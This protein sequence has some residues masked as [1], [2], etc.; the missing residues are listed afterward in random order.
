M[1]ILAGW[2]QVGEVKANAPTT[3]KVENLIPK[4]EYRF[5]IRAV[6]QLG[7]SEPAQFAKPVL[8]K[9]PWGKRIL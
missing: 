8:A 7:S 9:D 5:R 6:N 3:F 2:E 4:K 1:K